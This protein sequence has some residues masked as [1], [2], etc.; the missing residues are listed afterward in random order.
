MTVNDLM[1]HLKMFDGNM[2]VC[3]GFSDLGLDESGDMFIV[4]YADD[5]C[6][7]TI[8]QPKH[9]IIPFVIKKH[10]IP[11]VCICEKSE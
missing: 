5:V 3:I 1:K 9:P 8:D 6:I 11:V 10:P 2:P 7:K 4:K